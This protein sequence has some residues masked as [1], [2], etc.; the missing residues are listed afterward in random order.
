MY[1]TFIKRL[2]VAALLAAQTAIALPVMAADPI[3]GVKPP[4]VAD[5]LMDAQTD[6]AIQGALRYLASKQSPSGAWSEKEHPVAF[7]GYVVMAFL[8]TGNLP[9]EGEYGKTVARGVS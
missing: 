3:P 1:R 2:T 6:Q 9:G 4:D 5:V 7:T 8:A